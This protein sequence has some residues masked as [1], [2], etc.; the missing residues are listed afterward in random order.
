[1]E[2]HGGGGGMHAL[3]LMASGAVL[4][5][6]TQWAVRGIKAFWSKHVQRRVK[7]DGGREGG[8]ATAPHQEDAAGVKGNDGRGSFDAET[9][10][11]WVAM[12]LGGHGQTKYWVSSGEL[13]SYP[14]G[15]LLATVEGFDVLY[16][17]RESSQGGTVHQLSRKLFVFR[18]AHTGEVLERFDGAPVQAVRYPYQKISYALTPDGFLSTEVTQGSGEN[19]TTLSGTSIEAR[20]LGGGRPNGAVFSCPVFINMETE[21]GATY[22]CY[23]NY[24]FFVPSETAATDTASA[25][26][27]MSMNAATSSDALPPHC[28]WV[29]YGAAPPFSSTAVMHIV[30]WRVDTFKELPQRMRD[31][32]LRHASGW[33]EP[34]MS[35]EE[36][37]KMMMRGDDEMTNYS[38][39]SY[40]EDGDG[41]DDTNGDA[42]NHDTTQM[43]RLTKDIL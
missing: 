38:V 3:P 31:Y 14:D 40:G 2:A 32:T 39:S 12:R 1:M 16:C 35:L 34:P 10:E 18:D 21:S 41:A 6:V 13:H 20:R 24:D 5:P 33:C 36:V 26:R 19:L 28:S 23:E 29:R 42:Y 11:R 30:S 37:D 25:G 15:E 8:E 4:V 7:A 17:V 43:D 22:A 27:R 9:F